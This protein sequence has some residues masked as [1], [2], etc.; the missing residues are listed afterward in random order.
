V[1]ATVVGVLLNKQP[2]VVLV[3]VAVADMCTH[4]MA[5]QVIQDKV[6]Q[7]V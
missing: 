7:A 6:I 1:E 3:A 5:E 4:M 2:E